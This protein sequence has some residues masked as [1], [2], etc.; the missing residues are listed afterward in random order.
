[1][2]KLILALEL[3]CGYLLLGL[4]AAQ[5]Q[6][7]PTKVV[8]SWTDSTT[9]VCTSAAPNSCLTGY[10]VSEGA[11]VLSS[12]IAASATSYTITPLPSPG[13]HTYTLVAVGRDQN[14][15]TVVSTPVTAS[16]VVPFAL[17]APS[18]FSAATQ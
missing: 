4:I 16:V 7:A 15:A 1:M 17:A 11:T 9:P 8:L 5:A 14:G 3:A 10:G 12:N 2:K 18:G 13:S 6:A